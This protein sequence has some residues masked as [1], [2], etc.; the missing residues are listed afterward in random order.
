MNSYKLLRWFYFDVLPV[1]WWLFIFSLKVPLWLFVQYVKIE[2]YLWYYIFYF[3][4]E[5]TV[6]IWI[7]FNVL[8]LDLLEWGSGVFESLF[9]SL[10]AILQWIY[11]YLYVWPVT[12]MT[13][14]FF[15]MVTWFIIKPIQWTIIAILWLIDLW[16]WITV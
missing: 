5:L 3:P 11:E 15:W 7:W 1:L 6:R 9:P 10:Y 16:W 4:V 12:I 8:Y 13:N 14:T 2:Q